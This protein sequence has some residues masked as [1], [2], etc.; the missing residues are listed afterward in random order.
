MAEANPGIL[1]RWE[2]DGRAVELFFEQGRLRLSFLG[3]HIVRVRFTPEEA[4]SPRRSWDVAVPDD[5]FPAPS[6]EVSETNDTLTIDAGLLHLVLSK[7][8][9]ALSCSD[10]EG[11]PFASDESAVS[12]DAA[13]LI[14]SGLQT[15]EGDRTPYALPEGPAQTEVRLKKQI[16]G[17]EAYYGFGQ[18]TGLLDR[19]GRK[20]TNWT[21]DPAWGHARH[22]DN[23]YQAHPF[24]MALRPGL[25]WGCFLHSSWYSQFDVGATTW[26]TL[27]II[28]HGGELD[29]YLFYG[30]TPA[31]VVDQLTQ[32]TGRPFMPPLWALGYHQ[33]RWSYMDAPEM[34]E[35]AREF[36]EREIPID[37]LH[38]DIDYMH[39]YRDFTW[40]PE[41]FPDPAGLLAD[42]REQ[43]IRAV[44]IIDP[45]VK[46]DLHSGY[47]VAR[48]GLNQRMFI[49]TPEEIPFVGYCWPDAALFPDFAQEKVRAWWGEQHK[50]HLEAGVAG[51]WNDMNEPAI[52]DR[53]FSEGF[54]KQKPMPLKTPQGN[55]E[56]RTT[57][58]ETHNL[59]G[60]L[61]S[62]ATHEGLRHL[63]PEER[64]W[65]LTRSA[66][67]GIQQWAA[68]W[69]GDN[70]SWWEHLEMSLPQLA[71][72]GV[73]GL[74]Y[75]GVD[76]GGF[77]DN[78][79]SELFARWVELGTF[80]PFMRTHTGAGTTRQ[81]PWS[82]GPEVEEI[83]RA[84]IQFRYRL[85][86]YL[87]TLAHET[88][89]TG[90]P[91]FRP[92]F[93]DFPNDPTTY[94]R[95]DQIMVGPH[96]L[97]APIYHPGNEYRMVYLP[98]G[99]WYDFWSGKGF[100][101]PAQLTVHAPLGRIPLFVRGGAVLPLGNVRQSTMEPLTELALHLYPAGDSAWRWVE[102]DGLSF[103]FKRGELAATTVRLSEQPGEISVCLEARQGSFQLHPRTLALHIHSAPRPT[104]ITLDGTAL[105]SWQWDETRRAAILSWQDDGATH[106]VRVGIEF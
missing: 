32:L 74:P 79:S 1:Q 2:H 68:G 35:L 34:R 76:I 54:S 47:P 53:P 42:L 81:E 77:F 64:P 90:L 45:G 56:E 26:E 101:G 12:W 99:S 102:D 29:Y 36:R 80:Y 87:Y 10:K 14:G 57:H 63:R 70:S 52:F 18:R 3:E 19:R 67:T 73:S 96:L 49:E 65:V 31:E 9:G 62:R 88:H 27:E 78:P 97:V 60:Y 71:S 93:F 103:A 15:R 89:L 91:I 86:P 8:G 7:D 48:E 104:S 28:T 40:H 16:V 46:Y 38:F 11:Q 69:M 85:L 106:D 5:A 66:F 105:D 43:G 98:E 30:P 58:A 95:H 55:E 75:V 13:D 24:F 23:M 39:G 17:Q 100:T 21:M 50:G 37:V 6:L 20:I 51:I 84:A 61:M 4:F 25:A 22:L 94:H 33:S 82:F 92:L 41:R 83:A 44:T 72:M 59:Y